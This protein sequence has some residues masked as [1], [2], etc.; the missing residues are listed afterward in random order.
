M[1]LVTLMKVEARVTFNFYV[2]LFSCVLC[3]HEYTHCLV[4]FPPTIPFN[5]PQLTPYSD[6]GAIRLILQLSF[7]P[8]CVYQV[9]RM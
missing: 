1:G 2:L 3:F 4:S 6:L 7:F 5:T 9:R 8:R